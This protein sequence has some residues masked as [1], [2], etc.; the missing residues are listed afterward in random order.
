[1]TDM[2]VL[3]E[4]II[5]R[6]N[7]F[8]IEFNLNNFTCLDFIYVYRIGYME[9]DKFIYRFFFYSYYIYCLYPL[10]WCFPTSVHA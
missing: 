10:M 5:I 9:G 1:M 8:M 2:R 7:S 6:I 4:W 3:I